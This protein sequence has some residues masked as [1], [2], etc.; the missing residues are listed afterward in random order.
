M[1]S[2][3]VSS[4][5]G[6]GVVTDR[7][8]PCFVSARG[9]FFA[10]S[11]ARV[12]RLG[13]DFCAFARGEGYE[14]SGPGSIHV[15]IDKTNSAELSEAIN[16]SMYDWYA[17]AGVCFAYLE[18][19]SDDEE[20][21]RVPAEQFPQGRWFSRGWTLQGLIA[22]RILFFVSREWSLLGTK[23]ALASVVEEI[24]GINREV[25]THRKRL[26]S[27]SVT[28]RMSWASRRD[29][30]REED[31]AYSL[32]GIFGIHMATIYGEGE[33][34]FLRLQEEI[35]KRVPDQSVLLW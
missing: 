7:E 6:A 26:S 20:D 27:V 29:T 9:V 25:L 2:H 14:W 21:P 12:R 34:A 32:L 1:A 28:R 3:G 33:N 18:D 17:A 22:P 19:V 35:L 8:L 5:V 16:N 11:L 10:C 30:T 4:I 15:C 24:T 13:S 31:K 23:T